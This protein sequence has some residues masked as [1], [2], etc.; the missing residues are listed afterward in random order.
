MHGGY[1][2]VIMDVHHTGGGRHKIMAKEVL[3]FMIRGG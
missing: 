3:A 2:G 1:S